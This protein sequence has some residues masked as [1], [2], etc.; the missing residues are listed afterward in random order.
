[1][2]SP[3]PAPTLEQVGDWLAASVATVFETNYHLHAV[4]ISQESIHIPDDKSFTVSIGFSGQVDVAVQIRI[5][6]AT[7]ARLA[8]AFLEMPASELDEPTVGDAMGELGNMVVG[9]I[10]SSV[11][12]LGIPCEMSIPIVTFGTNTEP[13][14]SSSQTA[15]TLAFAFEGGQCLF[16]VSL[17]PKH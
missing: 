13:P 9:G 6:S 2:M 16:E 4:P 7:A 10:K 3:L 5:P 14:L 15:T 1:M 12:D 8:S 17:Q 11:L